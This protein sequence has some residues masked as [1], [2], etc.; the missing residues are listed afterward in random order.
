MAN[1]PNKVQNRLVSS[2]KKFQPILSSAKSRDV[3]ESDTV[4]I[5]VDMLHDLFGFDKYSEITSEY[6]IRNSYVDLA[7]KIGGKLQLL[8]E[9]KAIGLDLKDTHVKQAVDYAANQGVDWVILTNGVKWRI[10]KVA[11]VKPISQ[12]LVIELDVL[13][14]DPK[15]SSDIES[16][17]LITKEGVNKYAL[18]DYQTQLQVLNRFSI[19]AILVSEP[20]LDVLRRELR[21]LSSE[22]KVDNEQIKMVLLTEVIK[23]EVVEG[24]KADEA[25]KKISRAANRSL[26][27][28]IKETNEQS[29]LA[30]TSESST[31]S[32]SELTT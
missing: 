15:K 21:R 25:K 12:E 13:E 4:T 31:N 24:E 10:Y 28:N 9:V 3:N 8:I 11:F 27:K 26:R 6:A 29:A 19:G 30:S 23:R 18:G 1:I 2:I 22:V 14:L 5:I 16:L 7:I 20:V 32:K 17:F